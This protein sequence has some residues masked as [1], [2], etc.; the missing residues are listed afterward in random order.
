[1]EFHRKNRAN[2]PED[3]GHSIQPICRSHERPRRAGIIVAVDHPQFSAIREQANRVVAEE[4][5]RLAQLE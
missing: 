1:M 5:E 4:Q 2:N 3:P